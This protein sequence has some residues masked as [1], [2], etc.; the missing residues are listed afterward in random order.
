MNMG[1]G[2]RRL[3]RLGTGILALVVATAAPATSAAAV[4]QEEILGDVDTAESAVDEFWDDHWS[5][6]FSDSYDS[7]NVVGVFDGTDPDSTPTCGGVPLV[8]D[9]AYYC[10]LGDFLAYDV[11]LLGR[12]ETLGDAFLYLVV[13]HEWGHAIQARLDAS[14]VDNRLELQADCLAGAA[15]YG[16]AR[17]ETLRF[18]PEDQRELANA[19]S[20]VADD[21]PWTSIGDHGN[22]AERVAS[23]NLGRN[24][25]VAGC[26]PATTG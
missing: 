14:L 5:E 19:L 8:V 9:N 25:G 11:R 6:F 16:A 13:A 2:A 15:I 4:T 3:M 17:D 7:P 23:F 26:L 1:T 22:A 10:G 20:T 24:D 21:T 12:S 18:E